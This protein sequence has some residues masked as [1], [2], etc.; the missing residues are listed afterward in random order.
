MALLWRV[1]DAPKKARGQLC[2]FESTWILG[3]L[4]R[5]GLERPWGPERS[6]RH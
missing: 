1:G 3:P 2:G 4:V 5:Q 6:Q